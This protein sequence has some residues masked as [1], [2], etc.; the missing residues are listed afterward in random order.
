MRVGTLNVGIM[1]GKGRKVADVMEKKDA[2]QEGCVHKRQG[3]SEVDLNCS[4]MVTIRSQMDNLKGR[5]IEQTYVDTQI[6]TT[7]AVRCWIGM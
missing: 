4:T 5:K 1:I 3:A 7:E 2:R 6:L